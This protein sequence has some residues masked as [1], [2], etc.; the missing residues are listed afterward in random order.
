[1]QLADKIRIIRKARGYSQEQLGDKLSRISENGL[2]RQAVSDWENGKTEPKLDNIRDLAE[3]L[4]VSFD[5]LLDDNI[6]LDD[7]TVLCKVL[8]KSSECAIVKQNTMPFTLNYEYVSKT[9]IFN[10]PL[11]HINIGFG[12]KRAKGIIAIGNIATGFIS[13]GLVSVW[14]LSLGVFALGLL[15]FG[16]FALGLVSFGAISIGLLS[17]G[18][19]SLGYFTF[20]GVSIAKYAIGGYAYGGAISYGGMARGGCP[21]DTKNGDIEFTK[22]EI[23]NLISLYANNVPDFIKQIFINLGV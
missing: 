18:G 3:V 11:V 9:K 22:Q 21:I 7:P 5:A 14:L 6:D 15:V 1:M 19:V 20:V 23:E 12:L 17:F 16:S 4:N 10:M 2:S 13:L 8:G